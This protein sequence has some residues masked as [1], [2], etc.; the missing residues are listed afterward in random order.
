[1]SYRSRY[2]ECYTSRTIIYDLWKADRRVQW[3]A[4]PKPT[5]ADSMY[6]MD[7]WK[8]GHTSEDRMK[9]YREREF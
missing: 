3:V 8:Y 2:F 9:M 1:M 5:M 4:A 6:N 7:F